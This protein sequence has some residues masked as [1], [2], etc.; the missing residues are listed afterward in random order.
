MRPMART[1]SSTY[2]MFDDDGAEFRHEPAGVVSTDVF[3]WIRFN[4]Y[5][6]AKYV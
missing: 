3:V 5:G 4:R 6:L 2:M 1:P